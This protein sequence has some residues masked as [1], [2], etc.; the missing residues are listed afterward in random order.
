MSE[1]SA[2][3]TL[4]QEILQAH[5]VSSPN[6]SS[7]HE[8]AKARLAQERQRPR[9]DSRFTKVLCYEK[10]I[11]V[12][13]LVLLPLGQHFRGRREFSIVWLERS[14]DTV[15]GVGFIR[16]HCNYLYY[17]VLTRLLFTKLYLRFIV[18]QAEIMK[19]LASGDDFPDYK[20]VN[21]TLERA[22]DG[23]PEGV[24]A[25][26]QIAVWKMQI[27]DS[28]DT[29]DLA[30][31]N[32]V[33]YQID[34]HAEEAFAHVR[35]DIG[36]KTDAYLGALDDYRHDV[37]KLLRTKW[38]EGSDDAIEA[39]DVMRRYDRITA[40]IAVWLSPQDDASNAPIPLLSGWLLDYAWA[41]FNAVK[42]GVT[43]I[44]RWF[45]PLLDYYP[46]VHGSG[47]EMDDK[48]EVMLYNVVNHVIRISAPDADIQ[49]CHFLWERRNTLIFYLHNTMT[50]ISE[51]ETQQD[52]PKDRTQIDDAFSKLPADEERAFKNLVVS[53][54]RKDVSRGGLLY[55][56]VEA[57]Y[58][59]RVTKWNWQSKALK[60]SKRDIEPLVK[61]VLLEL[62]KVRKYRALILEDSIIASLRKQ[63]EDALVPMME[64]NFRLH[65][66]PVTS[67]TWQWWDGLEIPKDI[68]PITSANIDETFKSKLQQIQLCNTLKQR[69]QNAVKELV[70]YV[71]HMACAQA[72]TTHN[73][74]LESK[75]TEALNALVDAI[76][77][78]STR[79]HNCTVAGHPESSCDV[80]VADQVDTNATPDAAPQIAGPSLK[81]P[82]APT[83]S[84]SPDARKEKRSRSSY[85]R[86]HAISDDGDLF[87]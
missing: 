78:N 3:S 22:D 1:E 25:R 14:I 17:L 36:E 8:S 28:Q 40:R 56:W 11:L 32:D 54:K 69:D 18:S 5:L 31:F 70:A 27:T 59:M 73:S 38:L 62:R 4:L 43:E 19:K 24:E 63:L 86:K 44:C 85:S 83:V 30:V 37:V 68:T 71:E 33:F 66:K 47:H 21:A 42:E 50:T 65:S 10:L 74:A 39:N 72:T 15:M 13:A 76:K 29:S 64:P 81:R 26:K 2:L 46:C 53:M 51:K 9:R 20:T 7:D 49:L 52:R 34:A 77:S 87:L 75:V 58:A 55:S 23:G 82:R 60:N 12:L 79:L 84:G 57:A 41:S 80:R 35:S 48:S 6:D 16:F 61:A 67:K 45:E